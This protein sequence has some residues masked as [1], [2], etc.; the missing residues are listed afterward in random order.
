MR[1][2]LIFNGPVYIAAVTAFFAAYAKQQWGWPFGLILLAGI[3]IGTLI[4]FVPAKLLARTKGFAMALATMAIIFIVQTGIRNMPFLGG[5]RGFLS[6]PEVSGLLPITWI[7]V[8]VIGVVIYRIERS[9]IGR[10]TEVMRTNP[11]IAGAIGGVYPVMLSVIVQTISGAI[12]GAAGAIY[13]FVT[14]AIF[15]QSFGLSLLILI[16]TILFVGGQT[17]MWGTLAFAPILWGFVQIVPQALT[18]Y[19][20]FILG[21]ILVAVLISRPKG[22]LDRKVISSIAKLFTKRGKRTTLQ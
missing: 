22:L 3:S 5:R 18:E 7:I 21:G 11:D 13:P 12:S 4:G 19:T 14:G 15:P 9:R 2:G 1:A 20:E 8:L 10:A 17:T 6:I 16:W